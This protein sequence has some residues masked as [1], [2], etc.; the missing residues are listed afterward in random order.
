VLH[1]SSASQTLA[2]DEGLVDDVQAHYLRPRT[3]KRM[4]RRFICFDTEAD[5]ATIATG[6]VQTFSRAVA[7]FTLRR[8]DSGHKPATYWSTFDEGPDELWEW[9]A[10]KAAV[11]ETLTVFAHNVQYDALL[12]DAV[13]NLKAL[14]WTMTALRAQPKGTNP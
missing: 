11:N 14:G 10:E 5:R 3:S 8:A 4:P 13:G 7:S 2:E 6:E 1:M 9:I 12:S